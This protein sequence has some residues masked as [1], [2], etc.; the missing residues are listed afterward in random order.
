[1]NVEFKLPELG[2]NITSG[3]VVNVLVHEGQEIAAND[4]VVDLETDK[5]VVEI[6]CPHAGKIGKILVKKGQTVKVGQPLLTVEAEAAAEPQ[7]APVEKVEKVERA[8]PGDGAKVP[9]AAAEK[10][11]APAGKPPGATAGSS[12]SAHGWRW[13]SV[14]VAI[15]H[16]QD[17]PGSRSVLLRRV[18]RR[19]L[20]AGVVP[21]CTAVA[22]LAAVWVGLFHRN[23]YTRSMVLEQ[24]I[25]FFNEE[26]PAAG[27][28]GPAPQVYP[29]SPDVAATADARWRPIGGFLGRSG[30][31]YDLSGPGGPRATLYV[32]RA[33]IKDL[34]PEPP[35]RPAFTTANCST[36]AW[37]DGELLYVLV[38][39]G[40]PDAYRSHLA[41][42]RGPMA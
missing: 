26:Q 4:G 22:L 32:V 31:A 33:T 23:T 19:W 17:A 16:E 11:P 40:G 20:L 6:P 25:V 36:A 39:S 1:M 34:P 29:F 38:V 21:I 3:D 37:Q 7:A 13:G 15:L 5:A 2:E 10:P 12:S 8:K 18:S 42:A 28:I 14:H 27:S 9:P 30:V 24:A 41:V 35:V